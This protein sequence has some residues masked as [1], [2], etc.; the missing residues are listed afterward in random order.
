MAILLIATFG[1]CSQSSNNATNDG[2][3]NVDETEKVS[4]AP[5]EKIKLNFI[6]WSTAGQRTADEAY[7]KDFNERYPN[8]EVKAEFVPQDYLSKLNTLIA[9]NTPPDI[10]FLNEYLVFDW[11]ANGALTDLTPYF[12]AESNFNPDDY[13]DGAVYQNEGKIWGVTPGVEI[14]VLYY[15]KELFEQAN[16]EPSLDPEH[17]WNWDQFVDAAKKL[18]V[19]TKDKHPWEVGFNDMSIK[20]YGTIAPTGW[21]FLL[22]LLKSNESG[23]ATPDGKELAIDKPEGIKV[24]QSV[25]DLINKEKVAPSPAIQQ[26]LP[27]AAQMLMDKQIAMFIGGTWEM[28]T[29]GDAKYDVGIA[30]LPVFKKPANI[31]WGAAAVIPK[32]TKYPKEAFMFLKDYVSPETGLL[33]S[34][35]GSWMPN[36]KSWYIDEEKFKKWTDNPYHGEDFMKVVPKIATEIAEVPENITLKN[37]SQIVEQTIMPQLD[38]LWTGDDK[39]ASSVVKGLSDKVKQYLQGSWR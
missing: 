37:F 20:T 17:P 30:P 18:T 11:A 33:P 3:S 15:N 26:G 25:G 34:S 32:G 28:S 14:I 6:T 9:A 36:M 39:D 27:T 19:D 35:Q 23:F 12:E 5:Q 29:F 31:I 21:L 4:G 13:V 2:N 8:I 22:P 1:G 24:L 16:V 7:V 38:R 10:A